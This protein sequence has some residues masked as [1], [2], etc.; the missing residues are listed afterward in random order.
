MLNLNSWNN[1][2][3]YMKLIIHNWKGCTN[4]YYLPYRYQCDFPVISFLYFLN[5]ILGSWLPCSIGEHLKWHIL[6]YLVKCVQEPICSG[7]GNLFIRN[8]YV[9]VGIYLSI[10]YFHF[11]PT[12]YNI[13]WHFN[14]I[15]PSWLKC[16]YFFIS[17]FLLCFSI[18]WVF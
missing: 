5:H 16:Y 1:P 11:S 12:Q 8:P 18:L 6:E 10:G 9:I 14:S 2:D 15:Y 13:L 7:P 4:I 17:F 3:L